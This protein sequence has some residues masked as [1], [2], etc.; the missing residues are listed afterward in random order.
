M[1]IFRI[2]CYLSLLVG[3]LATLLVSKIKRRMMDDI[4]T[5][6][7]VTVDGVWIGEWIY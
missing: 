2:C 5:I 6:W 3:Y 7:S 4:A 1:L